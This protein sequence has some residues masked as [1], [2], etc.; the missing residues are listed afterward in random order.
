MPNMLSRR[1]NAEMIV[2]I[3][4]IQRQRNLSFKNNFKKNISFRYI[5]VGLIT[6]WMITCS[7]LLKWQN[8]KKYNN[9][10]ELFNAGFYNEAKESF[11]SFGNYE[12]SF[13]Y[14]SES[15]R[16]IKYN[17]GQQLLDNNAYID[18]INV[19]RSLDN[20]KDS[21]NKVNEALYKQGEY[22]Y[23]Q[24]NY[25][26]AFKFFQ[27]SN[28]YGKSSLYIAD[29]TLL[30]QEKMQK[31]IYNEGY[32]LFN[33]GEYSAALVELLKIEDYP[34]VDKLIKKC[35]TAIMRKK[36][37]TT[38]SSGLHYSV[39]IKDDMD[40]KLICTDSRYIFNDWD[41]II[42]I[43]GFGTMIIGL[44]EDG[45][46]KI[47]GHPDKYDKEGNDI[48]EVDTSDWKDIVQISSGQQHVV[49]LNEDGEVV[50]AG[51]IN[52]TENWKEIRMIATGWGHTVGLGLNNEIYI[53]GNVSDVL[54][55]GV[56]ES[57]G[58]WDDIIAIDTGG[59]NTDNVYGRG[60]I[61]GLRKG[62]TVIAVGDNDYGQ[63][64]VYGEEWEDIIAISAGD[65]HTVGLK[66]DG[67]VV[68]TEIPSNA[69]VPAGKLDEYRSACN[70]Y[71][72][73]WKGIV[74][75]SA[76]YGTTLGLNENGEIVSAGFDTD[77]QIPKDNDLEWTNI[78]RYDE[79]YKK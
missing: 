25:E 14:L 20:F 62:G 78:V 10:I 26:E 27:D 65:F 77:R 72:E 66:S 67:S 15:L 40:N 21:K 4:K 76:G 49:G 3:K 24:G 43:S 9:A 46:V 44:N 33:C 13:F 68:A 16:N 64:N 55:R 22:L 73:K 52:G 37:A 56:E 19:F 70:V 18:A 6:I 60:H 28:G 31:R 50:S 53:T 2:K 36:L 45:T 59:G 1:N 58:K 54:K 57:K 12:D 17:E 7:F 41:N 5:F 32:R 48:W 38:I 29:I 75:I 11:D 30:L 71:G 39:A 34:N 74:A 63:C 8:D 51:L 79:W 23:E 47:E 69:P 61:V 42:S 35:N